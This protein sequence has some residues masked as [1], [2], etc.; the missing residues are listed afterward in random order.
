MHL[1]LLAALPIL[2]GSAAATT[3][4]ERV[5]IVW[6]GGRPHGSVGVTDGAIRGGRA[7]FEAKRDG[8]FRVEFE[9]EGDIRRYGGGATIVRV[10]DR[11]HPFSFF[12]RDV[13][14]E[15]PI[16][17]PAYGVAVTQSSDTRTYAQ[18]AEAVDISGRQTKLQR[19][20]SE[21][22]ETFVSA[23]AETRPLQAPTW[24]G[25]SR[26]VRI[27]AVSE[28]L[29]SIH[30]RFHGDDL[31]LPETDN[32][33]TGYQ[34]LMGRGWGPVDRIARRLEDG[35]LPILHG[36]LVDED[37]TYQSISFAG[38]EAHPLRRD[39]LRGTH[40]LVA[41]GHGFGHMFTPAQRTRHDALVS[42]EDSQPEETVLHVRI[43]ATNTARV[44]RYAFFRNPAP[45]ATRKYDFDP[46][47]GFSVFGS[48]RV[49]S[50]SLMNGKPLGQEE[51]AVELEPGESAVFEIRLPHRPIPRDRAVA[52][53]R[54]SF[55]DRYEA[56][57]AFWRA[58]RAGAAQI[59][60]PEAAITERIEAGLLHLDLISYGLEPSGTLV[61]AIGIYTAIG[62]ESAPI[63]Q[64]MDSMGWHDTARRA[65]DFFLQKQHDDGLIQ[66]FGGYMLE[67][68][69][70]LWSMG[71]HYRYTRDDAWVREISPKLLRACDYMLRWRQRNLR[72]DLRGKGYGLLEGKTA[73]PEDPFRSF[74]LNG[75]AY[76]GLA[77]TAEMLQATDPA[78]ASRLRNEAAALKADIRE[79][80]MLA[81]SRSPV[82]PLGD[83][84]WSP[85]APP[86]VEYRGPL[87]LYADG[88]KWFTHGSMAVRDSLLGPVYLIY[89]E[90]LDPR[91]PAA[92]FLLH[93]HSE[94][95]T[96]RNVAFSQPYYSRHATAHLLRGEVK[97]FL[98]SYYNTLASLADRETYTFWE[99]FYGASAHKT[100]EE[101]WFLMETRRMLY[102]E[103]GD[104]LDL[105]GGI[106]RRY[107]DD[108]N[109]VDLK[110][111]RTYFGPVSLHVGS[112]LRR[113]R[114]TASVTCESDRKP[115]YVDLRLPHPLGRKPNRVT[116]GR[117]DP[118]TERVRVEPFTGTAAIALEFD[119]APSN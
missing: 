8:A 119:G 5:A 4:T 41:D 76:L 62:S 82:I 30:P 114:I 112:D 14:K 79:A 9:I 91:E 86:W 90:V 19:I 83:G 35:I 40:F 115:R 102:L 42:T 29:D 70:A 101:A 52:L 88:G 45:T 75:Y 22:E 118:A 23:A 60:L 95:M 77:R 99:H 66:N 32:R 25:L 103:R 69:A 33:P 13:R 92:T 81:M 74:M 80:L 100:H 20:E 105:L 89:Q 24:L 93:S 54:A 58:K 1:R 97:P 84:T 6:R 85:T 2:A 38:L 73:D 26:D 10:E 67:T 111:V 50:V 65:L 113:G 31:R 46:A 78:Q 71:E 106:P 116:G 47:H 104:G 18:I 53:S 43:V 68:G 72:D 110:N 49:F 28:R 27:F 56:C 15:R 3:T 61:P 44:P 59:R 37:I 12:L 39:T 109:T 63:I 11:A 34:F 21:P 7:V 16:L 96:I 57:R 48:G 87:A 64:F 107:L 17:I 55:D 98:K 117:Y 108:N 36:T 51:V 94:L